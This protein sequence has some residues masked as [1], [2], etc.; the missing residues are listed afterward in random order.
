MI[1][2]SK[3]IGTLLVNRRFQLSRRD[4]RFQS[5]RNLRAGLGMRHVPAFRLAPG[6]AYAKRLLVVRMNLYGELFVREEKLDQQRKTPGVARCVAH[7]LALIFLAQLRQGLP[8]KRSVRHLAIVARQPSLADFLFKPVIRIDGRKIMRAPR[9]RVKPGKH[10]QW[11]KISHDRIH[12]TKKAARERN[13]LCRTMIIQILRRNSQ[14]REKF[15]H[16]LQAAIQFRL[17]G[18]IRD[19]NV[20]AGAEALRPER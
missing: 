16:A 1:Q 20:I 7:Q 3:F 17:R 14:R 12:R 5:Q 13:G 6:L 10:Q 9:P 15:P 4:A 2:F 8:G 11:I 18:R 19:A